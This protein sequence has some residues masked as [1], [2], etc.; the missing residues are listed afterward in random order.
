VG[1]RDHRLRALPAGLRLRVQRDRQP[2]GQAAT[3][4]AKAQFSPFDVLLPAGS[5]MPRLLEACAAGAVFPAAT[6]LALDGGTGPQAMTQRYDLK[7]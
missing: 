3:T 5:A 2:E 1:Q 7:L 4:P 6:L